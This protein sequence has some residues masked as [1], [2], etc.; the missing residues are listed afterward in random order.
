[1]D[2]LSS[3]SGVRYESINE[4]PNEYNNLRIIGWNILDDKKIIHMLYE[5]T[6]L[7]LEEA[8]KNISK[9]LNH[10]NITDLEDLIDR[11]KKEK[12]DEIKKEDLDSLNTTKFA[13]QYF[14]YEQYGDFVVKKP[15][16]NMKMI[17]DIMIKNESLDDL[18]RALVTITT[19]KQE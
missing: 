4:I 11:I 18:V 17:F 6:E 3:L 10:E 5:R 8:E 16:K 1:M 14:G 19:S 15:P 7:L 2:V 12:G 13:M 9:F